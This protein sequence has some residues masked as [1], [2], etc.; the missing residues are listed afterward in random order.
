MKMMKMMKIDKV[1]EVSFY[2]FNGNGACHRTSGKVTE[3][4]LEKG[5]YSFAGGYGPLIEMLE[6]LKVPLGTKVK[7]TIEKI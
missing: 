6:E 4:D 2:E 3:S 1:L 7:V 5:N